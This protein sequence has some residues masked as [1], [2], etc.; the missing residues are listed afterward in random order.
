MDAVRFSETLVNVYQT[1][2]CHIR[3]GIR[4][5]EN[6]KSRILILSE[7]EMQKNEGREMKEQGGIEEGKISFS[8]VIRLYLQSFLCDVRNVAKARLKELSCDACF[9]SE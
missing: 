6:L 3:G 5:R 4:L 8:A 2:W 7:K 1:T 9:L